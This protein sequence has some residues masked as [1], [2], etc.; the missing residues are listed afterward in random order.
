MSIYQNIILNQNL[1]RNELSN[2]VYTLPVY[3]GER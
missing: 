3:D 2:D 1:A